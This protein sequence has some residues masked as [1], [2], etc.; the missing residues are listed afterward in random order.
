MLNL[1]F[2]A[3]GTLVKKTEGRIHLLIV[4][5]LYFPGEI[6]LL[7]NRRRAATV[8]AQGPLKCVKLDRQ[9]F[10]RLLGPCVDILKRN[11]EQYNSFVSLVV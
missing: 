10:E 8:Q 2:I 9:R 1:L 11:I 6:A 7:L 5:T 4:K 3:F